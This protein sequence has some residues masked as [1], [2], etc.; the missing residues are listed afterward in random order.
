[1]SME[2]MVQ[3]MKAKVG[4]PLRKLV[5]IKLADNASD[6]GECWPSYQHI[7][8]QCE[9]SRRSVVTH[10]E[11]LCAAGLLRKEIRKGGPKGN[12]SNVYH[13]SL[14]GAG[15]APGSAGAAPGGG[16]GAAPRTSHSSEP[17]NE[18]S[19]GA[20]APSADPAQQVVDDLQKAIDGATP[21][22]ARLVPTEPAAGQPAV[23]KPDQV[24]DQAF[25]AAWKAYPK[26]EG[27]NPKN[28]ALSAWKARLREGVTAEAMMQGVIRYA[29]YCKVK[30]SAGTEYV[31][32]AQRFFGKEREF[33]NDWK[34]ANGSKPGIA[35]NFNDKNYRG[36]PDD[37]LADFLQ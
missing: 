2:L 4:N 35:Q 26:R 18:P 28:K 22:Q 36:T 23:V 12:S 31:M 1:M 15:A 14:G 30:G 21:S 11:A 27:A 13:I 32:Q 20:S 10:I 29:A 5:L 3:A 33:E 8:D 25:E 24:V 17:V 34:A 37:Q 9:I 6:L 7:A 16:A 19:I